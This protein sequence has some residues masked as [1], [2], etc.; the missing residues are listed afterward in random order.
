MK[1]QFSERLR[2]LS[3]AIFVLFGF[4][5]MLTYFLTPKDTLYWSNRYYIQP[6]LFPIGAGLLGIVVSPGWNRKR[7]AWGYGFIL[8]MYLFLCVTALF[9]NR[10][11]IR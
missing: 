9:L 8:A 1:Y 10:L 11:N 6:M 2:N 3:A 4:F 7:L 5:V